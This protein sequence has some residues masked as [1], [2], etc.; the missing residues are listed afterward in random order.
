MNPS[1]SATLA[2]RG[3]RESDYHHCPWTRTRHSRARRKTPITTPRLDQ[4]TGAGH[5][6]YVSRVE[7][8]F[9]RYRTMAG[10]IDDP[11]NITFK[12]HFL[13]RPSGIRLAKVRFISLT[14]VARSRNPIF[15]I[16]GIRYFYSLAVAQFWNKFASQVRKS[17]FFR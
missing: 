4:T 11:G 5:P 15:D 17:S 8:T 1:G 3:A 9:F 12:V 14:M 6:L 10:H 16:S 13:I 2:V 7:S